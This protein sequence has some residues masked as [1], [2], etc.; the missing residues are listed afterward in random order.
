MATT[1]FRKDITADDFNTVKKF[2]RLLLRIAT[3]TEHI[4]K[5]Y[6]TYW[7]M[8]GGA[9]VVDRC[10]EVTG[11]VQFYPVGE[12]RKVAKTMDIS[13][14]RIVALL[15]KFSMLALPSNKIGGMVKWE[16][17]G[18]T[19]LIGLD[20]RLS[21]DGR[22][23]RDPSRPP[24]TEKKSTVVRPIAAAITPKAGEITKHERT[25]GSVFY[26]NSRGLCE[27]DGTQI[28]SHYTNNL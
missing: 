18:D 12:I 28:Y 3:P 10:K 13:E 17:E 22:I 8:T 11:P 16:G 27:E 7:R 6:E 4:I 21:A 24:A 25:D 20:K 23:G 14:G 15:V 2:K 1:K 26:R 9:W 5:H 19:K